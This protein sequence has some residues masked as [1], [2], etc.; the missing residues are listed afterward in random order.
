MWSFI[1]GALAATVVGGLYCYEATEREAARWRSGR[2][3]ES[4]GRSWRGVAYRRAGRD[5]VTGRFQ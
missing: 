3:I 5:P 2:V 1:L 4:G